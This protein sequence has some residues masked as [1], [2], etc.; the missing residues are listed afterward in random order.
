MRNFH[1]LWHLCVHFLFSSLFLFK[2][3]APLSQLILL[4]KRVFKYSFRIFMD[5][6]GNIHLCFIHHNV[7]FFLSCIILN[8]TFFQLRNVGLLWQCKRCLALLEKGREANDEIIMR[9]ESGKRKRFTGIWFTAM[10][11]A[12]AM[13]KNYLEIV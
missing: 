12:I 1:N 5:V 7:S 9:W 13:F 11:C 4:E 2:E 8:F 3:S 10:L 6:Y